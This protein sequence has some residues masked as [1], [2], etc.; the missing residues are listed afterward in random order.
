MKTV[1]VSIVIVNYNARAFLRECVRSI[2]HA[3]SKEITYEIIIVD[4]AST[5]DSAEMVKKEFHE[6]VHLIPSD[7]NLG[8]SKGNNLGLRSSHGRYVLFLNPD[9]VMKERTLEELVNFMD[10]HEKAGAATCFVRL[11]DGSLD[12]GAHR[13]FPTPWNSLCYF[14]GIAKVFPKSKFFNGYNLGW[15]DM[16]KVHEIDALVGAFMLTRREAGD[17]VG[18]WDENYFFYGEDLDF[19]YNLR[20]KN[21]KIYFIPE[22]E[23]LHHKGVS[24]GIKKHSENIATADKETKIRST[25]ERFKA[26]KIFYKKHYMKKYP[27]LITQLVF[28]GIDVKLRNAMRKVEE[29]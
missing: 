20:Q 25:N 4:N 11:E 10:H 2:L 1:D 23:I 18:W 9:T 19:C 8:F 29:S 15:R 16:D 13:G 17:D 5:D 7:E 6:K 21:W 22:V 3:V 27:R 12:D 26:M 14:S 28:F 24:A